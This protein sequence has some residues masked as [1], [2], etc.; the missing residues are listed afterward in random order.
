MKDRRNLELR[1]EVAEFCFKIW[2]NL[3]SW[4]GVTKKPRRA[5]SR[6]SCG[7]LTA[8]QTEVDKF[9]RWNEPIRA[10][11]RD[12]ILTYG[13]LPLCRDLPKTAVEIISKILCREIKPDPYG[14]HYHILSDYGIR[15]T[16]W[17]PPT[18]IKGAIS[19]TSKV[20]PR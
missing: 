2:E 5:S 20:T 1:R 3:P 10:D 7:R 4:D 13:W 18:R 12:V 9:V 6:P 15:W 11:L 19:R 17:N 14:G 16:E 8:C